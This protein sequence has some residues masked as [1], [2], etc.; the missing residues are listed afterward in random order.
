MRKQ[1]QILT[2][3][4]HS[5]VTYCESKLLVD[6]DSSQEV[7]YHVS[8]EANVAKTTRMGIKEDLSCFSFHAGFML[9]ET[10]I[11]LFLLSH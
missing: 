9:N 2:E 3:L 7:I 1:S 8:A 6:D 4:G 11:V 10:H 5:E